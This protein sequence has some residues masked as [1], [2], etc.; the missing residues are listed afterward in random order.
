MFK[1]KFD[2][3]VASRILSDYD[4]FRDVS[5]DIQE[6][7]ALYDFDEYLQFLDGHLVSDLAERFTYDHA[8]T[9]KHID[10]LQVSFLNAMRH[11]AKEHN[12]VFYREEFPSMETQESLLLAINADLHALGADF[13]NLIAG[14]EELDRPIKPEHLVKDRAKN[15]LPDIKEFESLCKK[16]GRNLNIQDTAEYFEFVFGLD[17]RSIAKEIAENFLPGTSGRTA[18]DVR[19]VF[20][21]IRKFY[22]QTET[23]NAVEVDAMPPAEQAKHRSRMAEYLNGDLK[24]MAS[25]LAQILIAAQDTPVDPLNLR[26]VL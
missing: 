10:Y 6:N 12:A 2:M 20:E 7:I 25:H 22:V 4:V 23:A 18:Q 11:V 15:Y 16:I 8:R 3:R 14:M 24:R 17:A 19:A 13:A 9:S 21:E 1:L 5:G 26:P